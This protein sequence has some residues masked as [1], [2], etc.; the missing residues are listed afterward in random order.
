MNP[1][2]I[3]LTCALAV[4]TANDEP[5]LLVL[6]PQSIVMTSSDVAG[7][8][9]VL[10]AELS[11]AQGVVVVGAHDVTQLAALGSQQQLAGCTTDACLAEIADA[12]GAELVVASELVPLGSRVVWQLAL[13]DQHAATV[14]A[15]STIDAA[16]V[17]GLANDLP[18][19]CRAL[20][21][22][23]AARGVV[24]VEEMGHPLF[25]TAVVIAA[26]GA[27]VGLGAG[28]G[29][30]ASSVVFGD[31]TYSTELRRSAQSAS[32]VLLATTIGGGA[33]LLVG[34]VLL[35]VA[36]AVE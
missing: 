12:M 11:R 14:L 1:L 35:G 36:W 5:R 8:Q 15:R 3:L 6:E 18:G 30:A 7:L 33:A 22:P 34:V 24:V 31:P 23:I 26:T 19:A 4:P 28:A 10:I 9:R 29:V 21:A 16:T 27:A 17:E 32:P 20:L 25:T 13:W 2:S